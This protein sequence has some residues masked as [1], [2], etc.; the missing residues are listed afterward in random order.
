MVFGGLQKNSLID[1]DTKDYLLTITD[2]MGRM[3]E[4]NRLTWDDVNFNQRYVTLY[5]RKKRG[6]GILRPGRFQRL[7]GCMRSF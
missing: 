6:G 2:T 4:I 1:P 5:T 3:G 7:T